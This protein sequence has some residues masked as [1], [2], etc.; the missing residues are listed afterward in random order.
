MHE[1]PVTEIEIQL[2]SEIRALKASIEIYAQ[3]A[4]HMVRL[5]D[6]YER[7][8]RQVPELQRNLNGFSER[9]AFMEDTLAK[10]GEFL[11]V[12]G[13]KTLHDDDD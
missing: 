4:N 5:A 7:V 3:Q 11:V 8:S 13:G 2:R 6:G 10:M 9:L 12:R 1:A